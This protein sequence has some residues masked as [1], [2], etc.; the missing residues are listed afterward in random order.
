MEF[1]KF[2]EEYKKTIPEEK[3]KK[4]RND[5]AEA[6]LHSSVHRTSHEW[7]QISL[8]SQVDVCV[9]RI[10]QVSRCVKDRQMYMKHLATTFKWENV[11]LD[12]ED[13]AL[14]GLLRLWLQQ[15]LDSIPAQRDKRSF[16][17]QATVYACTYVFQ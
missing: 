4:I 5:M 9:S 6:K 16:L 14:V 13:D 7:V 11:A 15:K 1:I 8:A 17:D 2:L 3:L 12:M 10:L